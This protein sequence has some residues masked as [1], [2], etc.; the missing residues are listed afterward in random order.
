MGFLS[1][2]RRPLSSRG[3]LTK[4]G[5]GCVALF[6][7]V[8]GL[9]FAAG[10]IAALSGA[11]SGGGPG[12]GE[13]ALGI[14]FTA[15]GAGAIGLGLMFATGRMGTGAR[16]TATAGTVPTA[17]P[18]LAPSIGP[19]VLRATS[20]RGCLLVF[21]VP[22]TA[23]WIAG[24][25]VAM[26]AVGVLWPVLAFFAVAGLALALLCVHQILA[27]TNPRAEIVL[28]GDEVPIG[29]IVEL[30]WRLAGSTSRLTTLTIELV[31]REEASYTRGTNRVTDR[32][33]FHTQTLHAGALGGADAQG[34][35]RV[36]MPACAVPTFDGR[37][38]KLLWL[39]RFKAPI[40][41]WPDVR[42]EIALPVG[43]PR[44]SRGGAA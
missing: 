11:L 3:E 1:R 16:Q 25:V 24:V 37:S 29:E 27:L 43:P 19:R 40:R 22:F 13:L 20:A 39:V 2:R 36:Q 35:L 8:W 7:S 17:A 42:D 6:L 30:P 23:A 12:G 33:E 5:R 14:V 26:N 21:L 9:G 28:D 41:F 32:E 4:G 38:N 10:G 15:L 34:T 18:T 44:A 31:G